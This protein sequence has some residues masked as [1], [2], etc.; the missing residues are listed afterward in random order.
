MTHNPNDET[1]CYQAT[2][3]A[4]NALTCRRVLIVSIGYMTTVSAIPAAAPATACAMN[5]CVAVDESRS[6]SLLTSC[7]MELKREASSS[8]FLDMTDRAELVLAGQAQAFTCEHQL[9]NC[10]RY[11]LK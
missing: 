11:F 8:Y 7:L 4:R 2:A 9:S 5:V 10:S 1:R 6:P 3:Q